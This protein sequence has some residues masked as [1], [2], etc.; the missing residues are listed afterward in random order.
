MASELD[1]KVAECLGK[2]PRISYISIMY[3][4]FNGEI[5]A[6]GMQDDQ[7]VKLSEAIDTARRLELEGQTG[8]THRTV[9]E[10]RP[11]T[12]PAACEEV[13]KWLWDNDYTL[14]VNNT[15]SRGTHR[16]WIGHERFG[17]ETRDM[18]VARVS[19]TSGRGVE[20]EAATEYEAVCKAF[21]A[22]CGRDK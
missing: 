6:G 9:Y 2:K 5:L 18:R 10:F 21:V 1:A 7:D 3:D 16:A 22:A 14:I 17:E 4:G 12:D 19:I 13:K 11:S 8:I 15:K 20:A